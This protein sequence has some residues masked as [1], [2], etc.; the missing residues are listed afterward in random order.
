M[1]LDNWLAQR[2]ETC[3]D[4]IAVATADGSI[5]YRALEAEAASLAR[6]LAAKGARR[7]SVVALALRP[8]IEYVAAMHALMKLGATAFPID[9]RLGPDERAAAIGDEIPALVV[10][11]ADDLEGHEADLP[12]LGE[13]DLDARSPGS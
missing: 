5:D 2:A 3:P 6:R 7:D 13:V 11:S 4:R 1:L 9:P 8:G 12:L 10:E